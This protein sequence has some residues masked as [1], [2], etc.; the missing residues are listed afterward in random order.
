VFQNGRAFFCLDLYRSTV[1]V[2]HRNRRKVDGFEAPQIDGDHA[3]ALRIHAL[4]IGMDA[5]RWAE[6]VLDAVLV[7]RVRAGSFLS[8]SQL[9]LVSRNKPQE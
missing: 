6:A 7:E 5:A 4:A 9:Q 8:S 1:E 3:I 2:P